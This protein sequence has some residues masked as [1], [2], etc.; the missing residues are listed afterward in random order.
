M[1]DP[2]L[3][4]PL[5]WVDL[6]TTGLD[7]DCDDILEI[8]VMVTDWNLVIAHHDSYVVPQ[9]DADWLL[10]MEKTVREMHGNS[11]LTADVIRASAD[12]HP[13]NL[14]AWA[15]DLII[16]LENY[17]DAGTA[18]FA[19]N[20]VGFDRAFLCHHLPRLHDFAHYR[21]VDVSTVKELCRRW[22][23]GVLESAPEK[24]GGH[25]A[26]PDILESIDELRHYREAL[27]W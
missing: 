13:S 6:E 14:Y 10:K 17:M 26:M 7:P 4:N 23:P 22:R 12:P 21:N 15:A 2:K 1:A 9:R 24:K 18:P 19:G 3:D 5:I 27:G 11:G 20:N 25:R 16:D 8:A